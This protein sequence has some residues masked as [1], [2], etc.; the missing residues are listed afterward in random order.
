MKKNLLKVFMIFGLACLVLLVIIGC[1]K[2]EENNNNNNE[3]SEP[4]A[5]TTVNKPVFHGVDDITIERGTRFLPLDG[6]SVTDEEDGEINLSLVLVD[7]RGFNANVVGEYTITYTVYDTDGNETVVKRKVTVVFTDKVAPEIY[8]ASD[9]SVV[10]G[11]TSF[12][13]AKDVSAV[14][15]IEGNITSKIVIE[16]TVDVWTLGEYTVKYS[17]KDDANNLKEIE[18]KVTVDTGNFAF[19]EANDYT[20]SITGGA[21]YPILGDFNLVKFD[22][23]LNASEAKE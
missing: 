7:T 21:I 16:G 22:L 20:G 11:D 4:T 17:V 10:V 14:D 12:T 19:E 1:K 6:V 8:G 23:K 5:V 2:K 9:T 13:T 3:P 15:N 18:R